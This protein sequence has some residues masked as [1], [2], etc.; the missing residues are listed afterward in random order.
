MSERYEQM[1]IDLR[2]ARAKAVA[3][4]LVIDW[5]K[6]VTQEQQKQLLD[7]CERLLKVWSSRNGAQ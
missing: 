2:E 6:A 5:Q 7:R 1:L 3:A 4:Q